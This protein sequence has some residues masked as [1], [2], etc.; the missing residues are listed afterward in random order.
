MIPATRSAELV[1]DT[2]GLVALGPEDVETPEL[3]HLLPG[4]LPL[5]AL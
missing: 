3:Q 5:G 1:V 4:S 2:S